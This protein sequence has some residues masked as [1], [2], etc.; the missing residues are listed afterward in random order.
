MDMAYLELDTTWDHM[1][2]L[3]SSRWVVELD[4]GEFLFHTVIAERKLKTPW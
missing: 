1:I 3:V 4:G 2:A